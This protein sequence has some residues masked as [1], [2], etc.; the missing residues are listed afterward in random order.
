[1]PV[2][3]RPKNAI[4]K[5]KFVGRI[6]DKDIAW[7][8]KI[9]GFASESEVAEAHEGGNPNFA[10]QSPGKTK[11]SPLELMV[12]Q[13]DNRE[14]HDW[15]EQVIA[16]AGLEGIPDDDFKK[17]L[18][19][20]VYRGGKKKIGRWIFEEAWPSKHSPGEHDGSSTGFIEETATIHYR[21]Y[22][23]EKAT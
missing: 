13:T 18:T 6:E 5:H 21:K 4:L 15:R 14:L 2:Q 19:I 17:T 22:R 20:D 9:G 3:G 8:S 1:M 12:A 23:W 16:S 7:F 11:F 10:W